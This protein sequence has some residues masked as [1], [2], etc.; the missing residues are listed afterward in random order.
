M[1]N[2]ERWFEEQYERSQRIVAA[3]DAARRGAGEST[4]ATLSG[5]GPAAARPSA[6]EEFLSVVVRAHR[7][8][9]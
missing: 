8:R 5:V 1:V 4:T 3:F 7:A 6:E 2:S 9:P